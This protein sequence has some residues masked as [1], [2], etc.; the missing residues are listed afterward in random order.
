MLDKEKYP[1]GNFKL[2]KKLDDKEVEFR[3]NNIKE[4]PLKIKSLVENLNNN[5]LKYKYRKGGWTIKQIVHHCADSHM[6]SFIRF[7]KALTETEPTI[8]GYIESEWAKGIDYSVDYKYSLLIIEGL[9]YR[10]TTLLKSL[11]SKDYEKTL[12]H[13]EIKKVINLYEMLCLYS[14]HCMH[15]IAHIDNALINKIS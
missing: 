6:N 5:Q 7:K 11:N 9:H 3:I 8:Q 12:Y 10:W 13:S 14:W 1:I 15:H 4:F 2:L